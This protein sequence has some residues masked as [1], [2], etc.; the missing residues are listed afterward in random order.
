MSADIVH[1]SRSKKENN[2]KIDPYL[3]QFAKSKETI[4][5]VPIEK[6]KEVRKYVEMKNIFIQV[7]THISIYTD[8]CEHQCSDSELK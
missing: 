5:E 8:V 4:L 6:L 3:H 2:L 1:I 7:Y